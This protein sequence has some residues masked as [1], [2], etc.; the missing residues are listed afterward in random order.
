MKLISLGNS[1]K[2]RESIDRFNNCSQETNMFDWVISNFSSVVKIFNALLNN[3]ENSLFHENQFGNE[4]VHANNVTH[5]SVNHKYMQFQCIHDVENNRS[6]ES[7][8]SEFIEKYRRRSRRM[9]ELIQQYPQVIH[10]IYFFSFK[11]FI[12][13]I[14]EMYYFI[15]SV[16]KMRGNLPFY[17]HV[18]VPPEFHPYRDEINKCIIT[19]HVKVFFMQSNPTIEPS[20]EQRRDLNWMEYYKLLQ[21]V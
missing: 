16:Q 14:E 10:F 17:V 21:S 19:N 6:Y 9:R 1:C 13:T 4:G 12:P 2:V 18:L 5:Y 8:Q 11:E 7:Q 20:K 3:Q 15:T